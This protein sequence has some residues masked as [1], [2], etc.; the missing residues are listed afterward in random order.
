MFYPV[1]ENKEKKTYLCQKV[2]SK[3]QL[4]QQNIVIEILN[5][6]TLEAISECYSFI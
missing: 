3:K 5:T 6:T 2:L 1:T 4:V